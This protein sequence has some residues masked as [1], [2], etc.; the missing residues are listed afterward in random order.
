MGDAGEK[1]KVTEGLGAGKKPRGCRGQA[2]HGPSRKV[3]FCPPQL[4]IS[5]VSV[6]TFLAST[7]FPPIPLLEKKQKLRG[8]FG[9]RDISICTSCC[10]LLHMLP[11]PHGSGQVQGRDG[12]PL[13]QGQ[14]KQALLVDTKTTHRAW[15]LHL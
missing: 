8:Y 4:S 14:G 7:P 12:S 1:L 9:V 11:P 10:Q 15:V 2:D 13:W 6:T 5:L 3:F